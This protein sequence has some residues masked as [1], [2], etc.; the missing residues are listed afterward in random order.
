MDRRQVQLEAFPPAYAAVA[1]GIVWIS[2]RDTFR[3]LLPLLGA[4]E[5]RVLMAMEEAADE[6]G[7]YTNPTNQWLAERTLLSEKD[8]ISA[9]VRLVK[10]GVIACTWE[11][12]PDEPAMYL[13]ACYDRAVRES[14]D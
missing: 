14:C 1:K 10:V 2:R 9:L 13:V 3:H 6:D 12:T 5:L 7:W 8:I 4:K 11:G